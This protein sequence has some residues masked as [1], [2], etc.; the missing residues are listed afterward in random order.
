MIFQ[1]MSENLDTQAMWQKR[2]ELLSRGLANDLVFIFS[3]R[4]RKVMSD[5]TFFP[6]HH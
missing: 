4:Y 1:P 2:S 6:A 5:T 3:D